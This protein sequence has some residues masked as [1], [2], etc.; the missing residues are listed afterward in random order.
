M[1]PI[2]EPNIFLGLPSLPKLAK[3]PKGEG[4]Q[5]SEL[6]S[7]LDTTTDCVVLFINEDNLGNCPRIEI[8]ISGKFKIKA[9]FDSGSEV[10]LLSEGVYEELIKLWFTNNPITSGKCIISDSFRQKVQKNSSASANRFFDKP[11]SFRGCVFYFLAI[12]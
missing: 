11:R 8:N 5:E 12:N 9:I 7:D 2:P 6:S 10:N 1:A 4:Q 3:E